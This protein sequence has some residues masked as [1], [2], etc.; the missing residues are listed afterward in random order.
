MAIEMEFVESVANLQKS[1]SDNCGDLRLKNVFIAKTRWDAMM[2]GQD[3]KEIV[4][5]AELPIVSQELHKIVLC[6]RRYIHR[7]CEA[8]DRGSVI[9]KRL[10]MLGRYLNILCMLI[11]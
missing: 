1:L 9:V 10:L 11:I 8:L 4:T 6:G 7:T 3:Y 2:K 5:L